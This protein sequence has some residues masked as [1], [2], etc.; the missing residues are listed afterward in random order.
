VGTVDR[1][2]VK[3]SY[4]VF[5]EGEPTVL[6]LP[7]WTIVHSRLWKMQVPYLARSHRVVTYDGPGNGGSDRTTDPARYSADA[8]AA[9]AAAVLDACGA[10]R[11]VAMGVS[12]GAGY[13]VRLATLHPERVHALVLIG[14]A[15]PLA[16]PPPERATLTD[17]FF[18]PYSEDVQGW[19]RYNAAYWQDHYTAFV[20][21]FFDQAFSEPHSTKA[22]EDAASWAMETTPQILVTEA[23]KP[24]LGLSATEIFADVRCPIL[25]VHGTDD[26]IHR[27]AVGVEAARLT[28]G[29]LATF[30]GSGHIPNVRDPVR[31]N[32]L[33]KEFVDRVALGEGVAT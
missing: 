14:A 20:E 2:G 25:V 1:D 28:G 26:R 6:L 4:E 27:H 10:E 13:A 15:L 21:F 11:V 18:E 33:V 16:P 5:G 19:G 9:D 12:L 29:T 31:F 8:Y 17:H 3:I 30:E 32:L 7:S 23:R 22:K 24:L